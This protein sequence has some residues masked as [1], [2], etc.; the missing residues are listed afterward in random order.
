MGLPSGVRLRD[1]CQ[2]CAISKTKCSKDKPQCNR[3][4]NRGTTCRYLVTQ[5]CGRKSRSSTAQRDQEALAA[6]AQWWESNPLAT[7][8]PAS[9][10]SSSTESPV[11]PPSPLSENARLAALDPM[12]DTG[13]ADFFSMLNLEG[14]DMEMNL[15]PAGSYTSSLGNGESTD[16][17]LLLR[18]RDSGEA[19]SPTAAPAIGF[20]G[21]GLLQKDPTEGGHHVSSSSST[22][23]SM[24]VALQ[25]MSQLCC[26]QQQCSPPVLP[27]PHGDDPWAAAPTPGAAPLALVGESRAAL[28]TV[29]GMLLRGGCEDGYLLAVVCLVMSKVLNAYA[30][31]AESC[32]RPD[33]GGAH[34]RPWEDVTGVMST[35]AAVS[36][37]PVQASHA[38]ARNAATGSAPPADV[39][40]RRVSTP[41]RTAQHL[42]DDLITVRACLDDLGAK[43]SLVGVQ[44]NQHD[45]AVPSDLQLQQP[46]LALGGGLALFS[47]TPSSS[48]ASSSPSLPSSPPRV[49][50]PAQILQ[51]VQSGLLF[52]ASTLSQMHV[53]LRSN[54]SRTSLQL[55]NHLK[56]AWAT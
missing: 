55:I 18:R 16:E 45:W 28:Q 20:P 51:P 50:Q 3:C 49:V 7:T 31:A 53:E 38:L 19:C 13:A 47:T 30:E 17:S 32:I 14:M 10:D 37:A 15:L 23:Q 54:L 41:L 12:T 56:Q 34:C 1:S 6:L 5:R 29:D 33:D 21:D 39:G 36:A 42:L 9:D 46:D 22:A 52:S 8:D 4:A 11:P 25:L 27:Q 35:N 48:A 2:A 44:H 43:I 24:A 40:A 26:M